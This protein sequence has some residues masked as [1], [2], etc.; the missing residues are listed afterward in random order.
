M[1]DFNEGSF[2]VLFNTPIKHRLE[3]EIY[4]FQK[5]CF[6]Q[7]PVFRTI[8]TMSHV[9][10]LLFFK[11]LTIKSTVEEA[12]INTTKFRIEW[13]S[14]NRS[15]IKRFFFRF[16]HQGAQMKAFQKRSAINFKDFLNGR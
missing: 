6:F 3:S 13:Y 2:N 11:L 15:K 5:R 7:H 12:I 1:K 9:S 14:R 10:K 4:E 8:I 16:S